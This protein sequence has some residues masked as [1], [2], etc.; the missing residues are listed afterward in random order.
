[1]AT[2]IYLIRHGET[3]WS[4][5]RQYAG[6]QDVPLSPEGERQA[7]QLGELLRHAAFTHVLV[8]PLQRAMNTCELAGFGSGART[9]RNLIEWDFGSYESSTT[10]AIRAQR[11]G[12]SLFKDGCPDGESP[13]QVTARAE[14]VIDDLKSLEGRVALFSHKQFIRA[15]TARWIGLPVTEGRHFI[16]DTASFSI[17]GL[18]SNDPA[19][20]VILRWN[21]GANELPKG[22]SKS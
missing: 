3:E 11:P 1:V 7:Q 15:L 17:L 18:E 10:A 2:E 14:R 20:P 9:E 13:D 16:L 12:W 4:R 19:A 6:H 21:A 8:S 5:S 22:A